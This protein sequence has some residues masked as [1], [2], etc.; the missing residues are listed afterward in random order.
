M[1]CRS[2]P[3]TDCAVFGATAERHI[4]RACAGRAALR[5]EAFMIHRPTRGHASRVAR[6]HGLELPTLMERWKTIGTPERVDGVSLRWR[7]PGN[8]CGECDQETTSSHNVTPHI[9]LIIL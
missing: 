3:H 1:T 4:F 8:E 7:G 9:N 6:R 5:V 2:F